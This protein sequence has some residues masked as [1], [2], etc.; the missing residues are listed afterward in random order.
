M[1]RKQHGAGDSAQEQERRHVGPVQ[2]R[3][4][5][6]A[7]LPAVAAVR[8]H[9][10][11]VAR[12]HTLSGVHTGP[13]RL[14]RDQQAALQLH[15]HEWPVDNDPGERHDAVGRG[16]DLLSRMRGQVD[17]AMTGVVRGRRC[18]VRAHDRVRVG[19][20]HPSIR[21]GDTR[22][23]ALRG[24]RGQKDAGKDSAH[25]HPLMVPE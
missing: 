21:P 2:A 16:G 15:T 19:R 22:G 24:D 17:A 12:F 4:Q 13:H 20:P 14:Q 23:S 11:Q 25:S 8:H 7:A 1:H 5:V 3:T 6:Q 10:D 18:L 9:A